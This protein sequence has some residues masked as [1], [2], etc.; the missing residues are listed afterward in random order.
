MERLVKNEILQNLDFIDLGLCNYVWIALRESKA[1]ITRKVPQEATSFL[2]GP[3]DTPSFDGENILSLL[4]MTFHV[5]NMYIY[6][7]KSLK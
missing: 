3:L 2:G 4:L 1:G 5:M 7:R 6:L